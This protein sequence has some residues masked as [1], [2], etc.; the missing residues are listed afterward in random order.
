MEVYYLEEEK[1]EDKSTLGSNLKDF[2][3]IYDEYAG[4]TGTILGYFL[5]I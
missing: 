2:A 4:K 3:R 5:L 1:S